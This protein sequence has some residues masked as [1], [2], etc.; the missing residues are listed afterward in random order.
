MKDRAK[1]LFFYEKSPIFYDIKQKIRKWYY[2]PPHHQKPLKSPEKAP[3]SKIQGGRNPKKPHP[4]KTEQI[5]N[6][7]EK[8]W[9]SPEKKLKKGL[10]KKRKWVY[11]RGKIGKEKKTTYRIINKT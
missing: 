8:L 10:Y 6:F 1:A 9:K 4:R 11:N 3:E 2:I 5:P 7:V